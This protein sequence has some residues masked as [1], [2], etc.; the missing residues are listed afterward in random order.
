VEVI[1]CNNEPWRMHTIAGA[2]HVH[3]ERL[4]SCKWRVAVTLCLAPTRHPLK[5]QVYFS[6]N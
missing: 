2:P 1:V 6:M 3:V 5:P 4:V